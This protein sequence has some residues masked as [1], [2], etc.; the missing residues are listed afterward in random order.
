MQESCTYGSVR[1]APSNGRPY[2]N[3]Q[4]AGI[5]QHDAKNSRTEI[6]AR[7]QYE[8]KGQD[9][10]EAVE[11]TDAKDVSSNPSVSLQINRVLRGATRAVDSAFIR[12]GVSSLPYS[13]SLRPATVYSSLS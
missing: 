8:C 1:G 12:R 6:E 7:G 11:L 10:T 3:R 13:T 9:H 4:I 5:A 2:R